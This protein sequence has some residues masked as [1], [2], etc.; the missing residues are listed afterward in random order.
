MSSL[1]KCPRTY[2]VQF[3]PNVPTDWTR[4]ICLRFIKEI[5]KRECLWNKDAPGYKSPIKQ[6][7]AWLFLAKEFGIHHNLLRNKWRSLQ[8]SFRHFCNKQKA[9][10]ET[11]DSPPTWYAYDAMQFVMNKKSHDPL[12]DIGQLSSTIKVKNLSELSSRA[13]SPAPGTS[14]ESS[15]FAPPMEVRIV[16]AKSILSGGTAITP[17][18]SSEQKQPESQ[19]T[20][21]LP[22]YLIPSSKQAQP[23]KQITSSN[24]TTQN[25]PPYVI[26]TGSKQATVAQPR[27]RTMKRRLEDTTLSYDR[28]MLR[29]LENVSAVTDRL[30]EERQTAK[31]DGQTFG[32]WVGGMLDEWSPDRRQSA[33]VAIRRF[34]AKKDAAR[35]RER[36]GKNVEKMYESSDS[37][38]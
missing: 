10:N 36:V 17:S 4:S 9:A 30:V 5:E 25:L 21:D 18:S 29:V 7:E 6:L 14:T 31:S 32:E 33:K 23:R 16:D 28:N 1:K 2:R 22:H 19:L 37:D 26:R 20:P 24:Q 15:P 3:G 27:Y 35:F 38:V 8:S 13:E 11:G 12:V 34:I